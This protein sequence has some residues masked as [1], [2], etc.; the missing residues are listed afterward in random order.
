MKK[1][2]ERASLEVIKLCSKDV[3]TTSGPLWN[4]ENGD[5]IV[6]PDDSFF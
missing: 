2:Y 1:A 3:I 4:G 5:D 6:L